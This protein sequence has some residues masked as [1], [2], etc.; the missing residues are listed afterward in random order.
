MKTVNLIKM[1]SATMIHVFVSI[2]ASPANWQCLLIC[3]CESIFCD[4]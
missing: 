1:L 4:Q 3:S 2:V